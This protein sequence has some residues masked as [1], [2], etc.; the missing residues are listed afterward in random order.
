RGERRD[1]EPHGR[2]LGRPQRAEV[3]HSGGDARVEEVDAG[4]QHRQVGP[5]HGGADPAA[6]TV[7]VSG[8]R[9][10]TTRGSGHV[11]SLGGDPAT[12][13]SAPWV[14]GRAGRGPAA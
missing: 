9:R 10:G 6:V 2:E 11:A 13:G 1:V 14:R 7:T 3:L 4:A 8:P 12:G 5:G